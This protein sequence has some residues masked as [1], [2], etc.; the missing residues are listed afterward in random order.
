[1][2]NERVVRRGRRAGV[3]GNRGEAARMIVDASLPAVVQAYLRAVLVDRA[4]LL[5]LS[6]SLGW[7][8]RAA[9]GDA[10]FYGLDV[11]APDGARAL[12]DLFTGLPLDHDQ[13]IP[14][15]ELANGRSAHVHLVA[16]GP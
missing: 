15:V 7:Q 14:F 9:H 1:V 4:H 2:R 12:Q 16:D 10:A 3:R 8:L 11:D 5:L 6:F 13:D